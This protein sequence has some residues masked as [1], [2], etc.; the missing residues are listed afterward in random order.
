MYVKHQLIKS[1]QSTKHVLKSTK[2][3]VVDQKSV[4]LSW[5]FADMLSTKN[6]LMYIIMESTI[7][8]MSQNSDTLYYKYDIVSSTVIACSIIPELF[9]HKGSVKD[10]TGRLSYSN[11]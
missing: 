3:V 4:L 8:L 2:S 11:L 9:V 6:A 7:I 5:N 10:S 1:M